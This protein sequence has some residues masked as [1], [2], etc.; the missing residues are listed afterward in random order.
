M[1]QRVPL[2]LTVPAG[3]SSDEKSKEPNMNV[4]FE[5]IDAHQACHRGPG[6]AY[7][8]LTLLRLSNGRTSVPLEEVLSW[9]DLPMKARLWVA[10]QTGVLTDNQLQR[11][12]RLALKRVVVEHALHCGHKGV[13]QWAETWL[14]F[15]YARTN[16]AWWEDQK[17]PKAAIETL[18]AC[19]R[20]FG[21]FL[22]S[23]LFTTVARAAGHAGNLETEQRQQLEDIAAILRTAVK[24]ECCP[25]CGYRGEIAAY[26]SE[27]EILYRCLKHSPTK[28]YWTVPVEAYKASD[29]TTE[30]VNRH[31]RI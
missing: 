8:D 13:E 15:G 28:V 14:N 31:R 9:E 1:R 30:A 11:L 18:A 6:E 5:L 20:H 27:V 4:T 17:I 22:P 25:M 26:E 21:D 10:H 29:P 2:P 3:G 12:A 16:G 19:S 23:G 24:P 7:D